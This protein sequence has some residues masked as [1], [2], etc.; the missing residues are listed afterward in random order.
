MTQAKLQPDSGEVWDLVHRQHGV[1]A[2]RQLFALGF[3]EEAVEHRI[4]SG[5]LHCLWRGVYAVGRPDVSRYGRLM[6]A[7]LSCGPEALISHGCAGWLW[8]IAP[9]VERIDLVVPQRVMRKRPGMH[10]HRRL[11]LDLASTRRV[12]GIPVMDPVNTIVDLACNR[13]DGRLAQIVREADRLDLV[14]PERLRTALGEIPR[15]PGIGR[16]RSLLDAETFTLTESPLE[17]RF[18]KLVREAGLPRPET[19]VWVNGVRVDFY[20]PDLGL[21]VESDGL[22][23]HR[24]ASQQKKDHLRDQSHA[25]AGLTT[26]RFAAAQIHYEAPRTM[27]TLKAVIARLQ[28]AR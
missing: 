15:R 13:S 17:R 12:Q 5:R 27:T 18:L 28:A 11:G 7:V 20:W 22:Q 4:A 19:Q 14:N 21:V 3:R 25:V 24:T 6:A 9:W 2:R 10:V 8:G 26:L 16:L 1:I 23:Y